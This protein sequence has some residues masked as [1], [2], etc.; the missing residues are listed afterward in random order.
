MSQSRAIGA[1]PYYFPI[2]VYVGG[3]R[4]TVQVQGVA[5]VDHAGN[6]VPINDLVDALKAQAAE[7][8]IQTEILLMILSGA[9]E[10]LTRDDIAA[11]I[12]EKPE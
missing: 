9:N 3:K 8:R 10:K 7:A 11:L 5:L 1:R 12:K 6:V 4:K 2:T